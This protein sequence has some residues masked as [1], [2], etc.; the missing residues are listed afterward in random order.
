MSTQFKQ[1]YVYPRR[2]NWVQV[3]EDIREAGL[4]YSQMC[5]LGGFNWSTFQRWREGAE[6]KH[7]DGSCMLQLHTKYCGTALT[8]QRVLEA[9]QK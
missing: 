8:K 2:V 4:N 5:K 7:S 6:L 1:E 3:I 9:E